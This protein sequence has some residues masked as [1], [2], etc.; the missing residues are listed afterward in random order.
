MPNRNNK[1][2][3]YRAKKLGLDQNKGSGATN[4]DADFRW[5]NF[6]IEHKFRD[7]N[8]IWISMSWWK[9]VKK[10]AILKNRKPA[11]IFENN[12]AEV[13]YFEFGDIDL[14]SLK[15]KLDVISSCHSS[16]LKNKK[17]ID[18]VADARSDDKIYIIEL[19]P[20]RIMIMDLDDFEGVINDS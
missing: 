9:K 6:L 15:C 11:I 20:E 10:Q 4:D 16:L 17:F 5:N 18:S 7:K 1:Y 12:D 14:L 8:T 3:K 2:E 13:V 19:L